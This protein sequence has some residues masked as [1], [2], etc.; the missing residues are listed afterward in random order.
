METIIKTILAAVIGAAICIMSL[1][2]TAM[3]GQDEGHWQLL[4][5]YKI[6]YY[7]NCRRC[8]GKWSGGPTASG[9]MPE[10]G[11]TVA[12]SM[13]LGTHIM[14]DGHEYV[15]EDRGVT[16]KHIDVYMDDHQE[17]LENGVDYLEVKKWVED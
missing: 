16:G 3:A 1:P 2:L 15:V 11:R 17:C 5:E 4:G 12:C 9:E 8:C 6:T 10:E 14:I 13:K 7:C